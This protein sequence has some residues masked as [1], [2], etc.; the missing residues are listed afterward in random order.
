[1]STSRALSLPA[2]L[3]P[4]RRGAAVLAAA[5]ALFGAAPTF[6]HVI[7][8]TAVLSGAAENPPVL[9]PDTV[10]SGNAV[11][12]LDE[13]LKTMRVQVTFADLTGTVTASH[14][15]CCVAPPTNVGVA[16]TTPTFTGFPSG[17]KSG[18]YDHTF[19][20]ALA[21]SYNPAFVTATGS[22]DNAFQTL[23][24]G[25]DAG[26]AYLNIHTSFRSGGEIRGYLQ[27]VPE[28]QAW[29]TLGAGLV[30]LMLF[31]GRGV[32]SRLS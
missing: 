9:P 7:V 20:M 16:T 25:L 32:R 10:G 23:V 29:L 26:Q 15:H 11:V 18:S 4:A 21:A 2:I 30:G 1:V 14:I 28:P 3:R 6:A 5:L 17:V 12:T 13:D 19:D 8:Y 27:P 31:A 24:N 22:V